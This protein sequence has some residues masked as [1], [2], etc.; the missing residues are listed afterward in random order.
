MQRT[1]LS[2][3]AGLLLLSV[4][5]W[6]PSVRADEGARRVGL[7]LTL[8][9]VT[10]TALGIAAFAATVG[11]FSAGGGSSDDKLGRMVLGLI[12]AAPLSV[13]AY[14]AGTAAGVHWGGNLMG[15]QG[16]FRRA[17][18]GTLPGMVAGALSWAVIAG[19]MEL[20]SGRCG[21]ACNERRQRNDRIRHVA[22]ITLGVVST[23]LLN[24]GLSTAFYQQSI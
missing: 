17:W 8:G 14:S 12:V 5:G 3:L 16:D 2:W 19:F 13:V 4:I 15:E 20:R 1:K 23:L 10:G 24:S 18:L 11:L 7:Q 9:S 6:A 21:A 22:T